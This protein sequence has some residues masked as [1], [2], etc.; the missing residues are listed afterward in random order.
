MVFIDF[1]ISVI[2][3]LEDVDERLDLS[4]SS[5]EGLTEH[6]EAECPFLPHL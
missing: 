4:S 5:L 1:W 3:L 2:A 6:A